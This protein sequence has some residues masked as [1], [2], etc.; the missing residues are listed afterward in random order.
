[1][2]SITSV[3]GKGPS[4]ANNTTALLTPPSPTLSSTSIISSKSWMQ[5]S[6]NELTSMLKNAY[7]TLKDKE[8]GLL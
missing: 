7:S 8:R 6:P 2:I 3:I 4:T 1:M 5:K